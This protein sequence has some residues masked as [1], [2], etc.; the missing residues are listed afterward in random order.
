[1][2][3]CSPA[4]SIGAA[5]R[6]RWLAAQKFD[7]PAQ[8]HLPGPGQRHHRCAEPAGAAGRP[9]GAELVE[10]GGGGSQA[11]R[12]VF[13]IVAVTFVSEVGDVRRFD[14]PLMAFLGLGPSERSTGETV[15]R[16]D[17]TPAGNRRARRTCLKLSL[18]RQSDGAHSRPPQG[19]AE[20]RA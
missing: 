1:M 16:G 4:T 15:Q 9:A 2:V 14:T 20:G 6:R 10:G 18:S 5:R 8:H 13:F 7:H 3:A 12:G 11:L 19:P 17:L